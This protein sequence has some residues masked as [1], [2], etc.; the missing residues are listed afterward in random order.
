MLC[1]VVG[2]F[3]RNHYIVWMAFT[4]ARTGNTSEVRLLLHVL[5]GGCSGIS[6]CLAQT[7]NQLID[8]WAKH[9]FV[10][11]TC[12]N[13]FC[14]NLR[15]FHAVLEVAIFTITTLLHSTNGTHTAIIFETFS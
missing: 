4:Q 2:R 12:L 7:S 3:F 5:N 15:L 10:R 9:T 14:N 8:Q 6:H 1:P 13:T 11:H